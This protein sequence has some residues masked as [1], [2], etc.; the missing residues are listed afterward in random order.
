LVKSIDFLSNEIVAND[1]GNDCV[2]KSFLCAWGQQIS[3]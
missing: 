2:K 1:V 3:V